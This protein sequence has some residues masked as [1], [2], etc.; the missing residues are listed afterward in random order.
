MSARIRGAAIGW[1]VDEGLTRAEPRIH[2]AVGNPRV[3]ELYH[4]LDDP[5]SYLLLQLAPRL[6]GANG[7]GDELEL[8]IEIEIE[9]EI[10]LEIENENEHEN[11]HEN[12]NENEYENENENEYELEPLSG[13]VHPAVHL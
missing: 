5:Y 10:E 13:G 7:E 1:L 3:L 4:Q 11:E 8:E 2:R 6:A 12:E 9:I